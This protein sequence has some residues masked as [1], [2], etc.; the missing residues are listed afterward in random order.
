MCRQNAASSLEVTEL[1]M[2]FSY[3]NISHYVSNKLSKLTGCVIIFMFAK[4]MCVLPLRSK[5]SVA[6][7]LA[8]VPNIYLSQYNCPQPK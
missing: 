7:V 2:R 8:N 4:T 5:L 1:Q 6:A 3:S